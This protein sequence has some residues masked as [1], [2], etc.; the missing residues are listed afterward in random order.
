LT[1]NTK[2]VKEFV[3]AAK[4]ELTAMKIL[5]KCGLD[6][7]KGGATALASLVGL[8]VGGMVAAWI[9]LPSTT[10]PVYMSTAILM[11]LMIISEISIAIV[12][13]EYFQRLNWSF[14]Q[15]LIVIGVNH[16]L[17]YY[18]LN[19]LDGLLFTPMPN[20][21]TG[22]FSDLF[23]AFFA[24]TV[25][26]SLWRPKTGAISAG[27]ILGKIFSGR[28]WSEWGW[29]FLVA[30]L[31]YPPIYYLIGRIAA[32]FTI[33]YYQDPS[34][35]LGLTL[36]PLSTLLLM[37]VLRGALFLLAATPLLWAWRG[38]RSGLWLWVGSVIFVQI[39]NQVIIQA[40]WLPL[41]LRIPHAFELLVDSF[42]QAGFYVWLLYPQ[43]VGSPRPASK[44]MP[45]VSSEF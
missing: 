45:A 38:G 28:V 25:I 12:L 2:K 41:G 3:M 34:L 27:K 16:Y 44:Q 23:P 4:D 21:S 11:P 1:G 36:P 31:V 24:A 20:M 6:V 29:R 10:I 15:R 30:W 5:K 17:L 18:A 39:A 8:M 35:N 26:A 33:N 42:I 9:H 13:G 19:L 40:Y 32:L 14:W 22:F 7:L 43:L 37:Q